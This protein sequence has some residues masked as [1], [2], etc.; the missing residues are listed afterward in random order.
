[1]MTQFKAL[2]RRQ[3][4]D[5]ES[6]TWLDVRARLELEPAFQALGTANEQY[7]L[8]EEVGQIDSID[9]IDSMVD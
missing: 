6:S 7:A 4:L 3:Q 5:F 8:F 2:L 1:M 9:S